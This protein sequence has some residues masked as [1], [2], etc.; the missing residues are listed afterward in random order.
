LV[1]TAIVAMLLGFG[2]GK[3]WSRR[4]LLAS[5]LISVACFVAYAVLLNYSR[6]AQDLY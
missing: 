1:V 5:L 6:S 4:L 3:Q 2:L